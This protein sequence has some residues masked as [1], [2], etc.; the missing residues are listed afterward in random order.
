MSLFIGTSSVK[1]FE[2]NSHDFKL[3]LLKKGV[4]VIQSVN[5]CRLSKDNIK[6]YV[7]NQDKSTTSTEKLWYRADCLGYRIPVLDSPSKA[8]KVL[9]FIK[10]KELICVGRTLHYGFHKLVEVEGCKH[11]VRRLLYQY[12]SF[13]FLAAFID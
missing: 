6:L 4:N 1:G 12:P 3:E 13:K 8:G 9:S 7:P 5:Y 2:K 10:H 11:K